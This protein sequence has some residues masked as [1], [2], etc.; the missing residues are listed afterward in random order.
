MSFV[1]G[2]I[3]ESNQQDPYRFG[4]DFLHTRKEKEDYHYNLDEEK[5]LSYYRG[6]LDS[7]SFRLD[8]NKNVTYFMQNNMGWRYGQKNDDWFK[9]NFPKTRQLFFQKVMRLDKNPQNLFLNLREDQRPFAWQVKPGVISW[10]QDKGL[11][12][13]FIFYLNNGRKYNTNYE[14]FEKIF[15]NAKKMYMESL[16]YVDRKFIEEQRSGR[17]LLSD[18]TNLVNLNV[19]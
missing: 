13:R 3:P 15:P 11:N 8:Q 10:G 12:V 4:Q 17:F 1:L 9:K 5:R 16:P 7:V 6:N 14:R 18:S 2:D 19:E